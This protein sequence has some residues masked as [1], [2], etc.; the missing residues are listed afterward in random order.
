MKTTFVIIAIALSVIITVVIENHNLVLGEILGMAMVQPFVLLVV[1]LV[2]YPIYRM[3]R[4]NTR[5]EN[6]ASEILENKR[7]QAT[8]D[9]EKN[10]DSISDIYLSKN[11]LSSDLIDYEFKDRNNFVLWRGKCNLNLGE[12]SSMVLFSGNANQEVVLQVEKE[13]SPQKY[14][15][16]DSQS[17]IGN[18]LVTKNG[19]ELINN[20]NNSIFTAIL[21]SETDEGLGTVADWMIAFELS[22]A[23]SSS[24]EV[25]YF[26]IKDAYNQVVGRYYIALSNMDLTFDKNSN[27]DRRG[28]AIFSMVIDSLFA[29]DLS[30]G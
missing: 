1:S 20:E 28:A 8:I 2:L 29:R 11:I 5:A 21:E 16:K 15:I 7:E 4:K 26:T 25:T 30:H 13:S 6:S 23:F 3:L 22:T 18:I 24:R 27:L 9:T 17:I 19:L 10:P 12:I 14:V